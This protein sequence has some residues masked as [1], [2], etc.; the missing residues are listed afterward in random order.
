MFTWPKFVAESAPH[1][2]FWAVFTKSQFGT[3]SPFASPHCRDA[4]LTD[5]FTGLFAVAVAVVCDW[6]YRPMLPLITVF[7]VPNT[8]SAP[9]SRGD[10]SFQF[11]TS[12]TG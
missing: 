11:G 8:S 3:K 9:P 12:Y 4:L 5:V 7:P 2:P 6:R 1:S 10:T